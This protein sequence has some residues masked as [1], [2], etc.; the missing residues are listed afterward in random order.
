MIGRLGTSH[1]ARAR[2]PQRLAQ[3][4]RAHAIAEEFS[5]S[6][7]T[8]RTQIRAILGKLEVGS[9]LE[10]VSLLHDYQRVPKPDNVVRQRCHEGTE[11]ASRLRQSRKVDL[12]K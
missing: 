6:V 8:V 9:Q 5:V 10:A 4:R 3:G 2:R 11:V 7:A 12:Q 1:R